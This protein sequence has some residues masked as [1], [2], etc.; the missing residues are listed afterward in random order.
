[1]FIGVSELY[2]STDKGI[3]WSAANGDAELDPGAPDAN[4]CISLSVSHATADT[5][6]ALTAAINHKAGAF[7]STDG[8][9]SFTRVT[10]D[11]FPNRFAT[12]VAVDPHNAAI[13]Y[14]TFSGF[15]GEHVFMTTNT[16]ATWSDITANLPDVP[17][18]CVLPDPVNSQYV[19]VGTDFGAFE[20]TNGGV[21][22]QSYMNGMPTAIVM[23]LAYCAANNS[24]R[25]ATHGR[26]VF[27]RVRNVPPP[28][29]VAETPA[30]ATATFAVY[31]TIISSQTASI[32]VSLSHE[33][34]SGNSTLVLYDVSGRMIEKRNVLA[35]PAGVIAMPIPATLPSGMYYVALRAESGVSAKKILVMK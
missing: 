20:T 3:H 35:V 22:W 16:G 1:M 7:V 19:Y 9:N 25:A 30:K 13:A 21:S 18:D 31:P 14:V 6:Y 15:G 10:P 33:L 5:L 28:S 24:I 23:S 8:G 34:Q 27:E 2:K 12:D 32:N 26:G 29:S 11:T 4:P 17:A